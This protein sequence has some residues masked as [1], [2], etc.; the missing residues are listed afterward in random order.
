M[1][2]CGTPKH[3]GVRLDFLS[4]IEH[5]G[6]DLLDN[7]LSSIKSHGRNL[8]SVIFLERS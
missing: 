1:D 7:S 2:P 4:S 3:T 8:V 5:I 6:G